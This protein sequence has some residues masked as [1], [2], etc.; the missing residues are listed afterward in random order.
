MP[1]ASNAGLLSNDPSRGFVIPPYAALACVCS[2]VGIFVFLVSSGIIVFSAPASTGS[3]SVVVINTGGANEF[4]HGVPRDGASGAH[5]KIGNGDDSHMQCPKE[6]I[7]SGPMPAVGLH[8]PRLVNE[9]AMAVWMSRQWATDLG[10]QVSSMAV[11]MYIY[12]PA[13]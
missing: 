11:L 6:C 9:T 3:G 10:L 12:V 8:T 1:R 13:T 4:I 7:R 2:C 5:G